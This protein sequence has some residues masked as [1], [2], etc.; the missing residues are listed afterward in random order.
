MDRKGPEGVH[1]LVHIHWLWFV[2]FALHY[3]NVHRCGYFIS[4]RLWQKVFYLLLQPCNLHSL[5]R[6]AGAQ[7]PL[8]VFLSGAPQPV[9]QHQSPWMFPEA[10]VE[11]GSTAV[12][13]AYSFPPILEHDFRASCWFREQLDIININSICYN[14]QNKDWIFTTKNAKLSLFILTPISKEVNNFSGK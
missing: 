14:S 6:C 13:L 10:W 11:Y 4:D 8:T 1:C 9:C 12:S 5:V 3:V 7:C 2:L